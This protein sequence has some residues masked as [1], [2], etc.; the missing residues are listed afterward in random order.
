MTSTP[1][2]EVDNQSVYTKQRRS[3]RQKTTSMIVWFSSLCQKSLQRK[4]SRSAHRKWQCCPNGSVHIQTG[5]IPLGRRLPLL[6]L[7]LS[8]PLSLFVSSSLGHITFLSACV[9]FA[10]VAATLATVSCSTSSRSCLCIFCRAFFLLRG[11]ELNPSRR[12]S[13]PLWVSIS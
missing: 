4:V 5:I 12:V 6:S 3:R 11:R 8:L 10:L 9:F 13:I 2:K 1:E 7:S